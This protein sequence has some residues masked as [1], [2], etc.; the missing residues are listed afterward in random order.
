MWT[1]SAAAMGV[2]ARQGVGKIRHLDTRTLWVQQAARG[3]SIEYRKVLGT[4]N[5]ADCLTKHVDRA[6]LNRHLKS[7]GIEYESGRADS[8]PKLASHL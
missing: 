3:G 4:D 7:M 6:T 2:V 1:D 8:A 5:P